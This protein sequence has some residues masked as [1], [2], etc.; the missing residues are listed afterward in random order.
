MIQTPTDLT[1]LA[2][3]KAWLGGATNTTDD[4]LLL[5]L[6]HAASVFVQSWLN[7]R[8]MLQAYYERRN[9]SIAGAGLKGMVFGDGPVFDVQSVFINGATVPASSDGAILQPGYAF[10]ENEIW[11]AGYQ[12]TKGKRNVTLAYRA[13]FTTNEVRTIPTTPFQLTPLYMWLLDVG[14]TMNS[15]AMTKVSGTPTTGQYSVNATGV[16]TFAAADTGKDVTIGYSLCPADIEQGVIDMLALRY[17]ERDRIG[18]VSK[19]VGGETVSFTQKDMSDSTKTLLQ[20]YRKVV[21]L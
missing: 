5:R 13:G 12:F 16:Y 14:V 18:V 4:E 8:I 1:T 15:T 6:I 17:R 20:Q 7:R 2:R 21:P 9:G 3:A 11:L 10:D 19:A